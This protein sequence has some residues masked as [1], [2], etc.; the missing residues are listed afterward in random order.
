MSLSGF[1]LALCDAIASPSRAQTLRLDPDAFLAGYDLTDRERRRLVAVGRQPGMTTCCAIYR[2]NRISPICLHLPMT[3]RLLGDGFM[4]Q[5]EDY[6]SSRGTDLQY[7]PE[8][9]GFGEF[10]GERI[11]AGALSTPYLADVLAFE[12]AVVD[13]QFADGSTPMGGAHPR[14]RLVRFAHDPIAILEA[15]ADERV[16]EDVPLGEQYV[17]IDGRDGSLRM[18]PLSA[19]VGQRLARLIAGDEVDLDA[20]HDAALAN[21]GFLASSASADVRSSSRVDGQAVST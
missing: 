21:V 13:L 1:Q 20:S 3:M 7:C 2:L 14:I 9:V 15:L 12:L 11:R 18:I 16:P 5:V 19:A 17:V 8:V 6:W 4:A 10:L